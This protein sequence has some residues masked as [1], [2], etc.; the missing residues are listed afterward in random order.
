MVVKS[1]AIVD[2]SGPGCMFL[3][4]LHTSELVPATNRTCLMSNPGENIIRMLPEDYRPFSRS[5]GPN[6]ATG[7][8]FVAHFQKP[9][10]VR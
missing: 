3:N 10:F 6:L 7:H 1:K 2:R 8:V 4:E 9:P 5:D